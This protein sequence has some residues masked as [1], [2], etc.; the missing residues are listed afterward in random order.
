[1]HTQAK[2]TILS[3]I[4]GRYIP[5]DKQQQQQQ[6]QQQTSEQVRVCL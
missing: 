5:K 1:M 4:Y 3:L 2:A 6:Q